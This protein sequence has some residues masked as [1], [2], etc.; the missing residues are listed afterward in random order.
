M[1]FTFHATRRTP[2]GASRLVQAMSGWLVK[3]RRAPSRHGGDARVYGHTTTAVHKLST[4]PHPA[5]FA[6]LCHASDAVGSSRA[7]KVIAGSVLA[8]Q[9]P[10]SSHERNHLI[11]SPSASK[12]FVFTMWITIGSQQCTL[13]HPP[14]PPPPHTYRL[15]FMCPLTPSTPPRWFCRPRS[16]PTRWAAAR[17]LSLWPGVR[18]TAVATGPW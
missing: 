17:R 15:F 11:V 2:H 12:L 18:C 13:E 9:R 10:R 6:G 3:I 14:H 7:S 8:V 1:Q 4:P 16:R 5:V